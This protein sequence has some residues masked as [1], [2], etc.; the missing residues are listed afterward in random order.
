M[1]TSCY[2]FVHFY[3]FGRNLLSDRMRGERFGRSKTTAIIRKWDI[4]SFTDVS[5]VK[6]YRMKWRVRR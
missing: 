4:F 2:I 1:V 3:R 5:K 6:K